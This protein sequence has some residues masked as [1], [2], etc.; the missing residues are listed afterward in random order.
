MFDFRGQRVIRVLYT[1][2]PHVGYT[3]GVSQ[4]IRDHTTQFRKHKNKKTTIYKQT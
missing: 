4:A 3:Q 2:V 1:C